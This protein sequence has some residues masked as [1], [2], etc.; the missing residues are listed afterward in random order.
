MVR[1]PMQARAG[2]RARFNVPPPVR[3]GFFNY[4]ATLEDRVDAGF[5]GL[6]FKAI[7]SRRAQLAALNH[8]SRIVNGEADH[9]FDYSTI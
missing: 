8:A 9:C 4:V 1:N 3:K 7:T 5:Y 2:N 6:Q